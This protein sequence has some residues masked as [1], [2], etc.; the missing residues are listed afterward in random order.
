MILP[1]TLAKVRDAGNLTRAALAIPVVEIDDV[2]IQYS[3]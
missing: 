3:H 1:V 2:V